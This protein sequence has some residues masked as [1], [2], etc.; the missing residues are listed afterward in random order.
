MGVLRFLVNLLIMA[1][2]LALIAGIAWLGY[3]YPLIF[4]GLTVALSLILGLSL[5]YARLAH[6]FPFYFGRPLTGRWFIAHLVAGTDAFVKALLAGVMALITFSGTDQERL[7]WVAIIF[8]V[9]TFAGTSLLRRLHIS[10]NAKPSRW[11]YFRLAAPLGLLF[12][13][14][15][16]F[17]PALSFTDIGYKV[18]FDLPARPSVAQASEVLFILKQKFDALIVL[19]LSSFMHPDV[20]KIVGSVVSVNVLSG[21]VIALYAVVIAELVKFLEERRP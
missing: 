3:H 7:L 16:S 8:A 2:E 21:F 13:L 14:A 17:F 19:L 1:L 15:L 11:G 5:E 12:S 4:A 10:L 18:I 6:E 20:A 9:A